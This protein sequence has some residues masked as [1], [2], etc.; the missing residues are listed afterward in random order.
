MKV[1]ER[2]QELESTRWAVTCAMFAN[3]N[4]RG[5][6]HP[7][8]FTVNDF[9]GRAPVAARDALTPAQQAFLKKEELRMSL[10]LSRVLSD[11]QVPEWAKS[12]VAASRAANG[13]AQ[14]VLPQL[15]LPDPVSTNALF[16]DQRSNHLIF[17]DSSSG[18]E[19]M[20]AW[21]RSQTRKPQ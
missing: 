1:K 21:L 15:A 3:A 8:A 20:Q 18:R 9:L 11:D 13:D 4:F 6:E 16:E 5:R 10:M 12:T 19:A 14:R 7:Q 2:A 17:E